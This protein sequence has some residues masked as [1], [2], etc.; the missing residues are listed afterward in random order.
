MQ[1]KLKSFLAL[2]IAVSL[3]LSLFIVTASTDGYV[4]DGLV[5]FFDGSNNSGGSQKKDTT[6]WKDLS[7]KN[8]DITVI[9][10]DKCKW[11]D[12]GYFNDSTK[13]ELPQELTDVINSEEFSVEIVLDDF[14]SKGLHYN[15]IMNC[16]ND[17]F[18]LFRRISDEVIEFKNKSNPRPATGAG[19]AL[20]YLSS[21]VT[22]TITFKVGG[23]S[24]LYINGEKIDSKV[25]NGTIDA[26]RMF[27]GHDDATR[28]FSAT[29]EYLRF[30]DRELTADEVAKNYN[31]DIKSDNPA[32][33]VSIAP[34]FIMIVALGFA[35]TVYN[36]N[37]RLQKEN[38]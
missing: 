20:D 5:G 30:Y 33:D 26:D 37:K 12:D 11:N 32:T 27:F 13:V 38:N 22:L 6:T 23:E 1:M 3:C 35:G 10:D 18:S 2:V 24:T 15:P 4:T 25:A 29:Y 21:R 19:V 9:L 8:H 7:G 36:A 14:T 17:Y 16:D 31:E 34:L 28:N